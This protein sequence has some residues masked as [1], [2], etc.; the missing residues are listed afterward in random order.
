VT[1]SIIECLDDPALFQRHFKGDTW[2]PWR[3]FLK[4]MF[5]LEMDEAETALYLSEHPLLNL[6]P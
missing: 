5:A 2:G 4:A 6:P 1:P 3:T